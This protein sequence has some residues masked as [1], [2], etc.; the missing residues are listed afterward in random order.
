MPSQLTKC[1]TELSQK[2]ILIK[3]SVILIYQLRNLISYAVLFLGK[4]WGV[5][6]GV[7]EVE[8]SCYV[9]IGVLLTLSF[10]LKNDQTYFKNLVVFKTQNF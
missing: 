6:V 4:V 8:Q 1:Q 5:K 9:T 7:L 2:V 10:K 3:C